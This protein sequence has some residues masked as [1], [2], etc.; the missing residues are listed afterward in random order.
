MFRWDRP[1]DLIFFFFLGDV[2][3]VDSRD[4]EGA[5]SKAELLHAQACEWKT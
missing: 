4:G 2:D 5:N 3:L 1:E